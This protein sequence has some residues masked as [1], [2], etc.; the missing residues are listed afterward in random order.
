M[1]ARISYQ[2]LQTLFLLFFDVIAHQ[3]NKTQISVGSTVLLFEHTNTS[4]IGFVLL[5]AD[6]ST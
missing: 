5:W 1:S 6:F 2:I 4:K 3:S